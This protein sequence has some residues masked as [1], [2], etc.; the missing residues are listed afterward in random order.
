MNLFNQIQG[1]KPGYNAFDLSHERKFSMQMGKLTPILVQ[2]IIPGDKFNINTEV[3][4]RFAPLTAP[5]MHRINVY[6]HY[7]FV[8]NRLVWDDWQNFITGG[9][10]GL[11]LPVYP[12]LAMSKANQDNFVTGSLADYMGLPSLEGFTGS[13]SSN[14]W[15]SALPFRAYQ[16]IYNE[17]YRDQNLT[18]PVAFGTGSDAEADITA[19]M[20]MRQR[21]WE[22]DYFTSALPW[23]QRGGE[24]AMPIDFVY[25]DVSE[26]YNSVGVKPT[27]Q[28]DLS[29][30]TVGAT[31]GLLH[32]KVGDDPVDDTLRIENLESEGTSVTI[33]EL[34]NAVRLQEWLERNARAGARYIEQIFSHFGVKSSDA[35]LQRPEYLGG[36]KS[37]VVISEVLQTSATN[38]QSSAVDPSVQGNMAGHGISVGTGHKA[39]RRFEEHGYII[40]IISVLP[41]TAYQQGVNRMWRKDDKFDYF[42]PEFAQLGEQAIT[43]GE[44]YLDPEDLATANTADWGYQSRYAEYKYKESTVHGD[45]R[46]NLDHWHMG[47]EF[48][49]APE[50]NTSFVEADPTKRIFAVTDTTVDELWVQ[51]YHRIKAIRPIPYFNNP[52]I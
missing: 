6:T 44:L 51:L 35:R 29:A 32:N 14:Y 48:E 34:R 43:R 18:D 16:L 17:Y 21:A 13:F 27:T 26:V 28:I 31:D 9:S 11:D 24:V 52:T 1:K 47:R 8:P 38:T 19:L 5:V 22:K 45:F 41:R 15:V 40:G 10:D 39:S 23:A 46:T 49:T 42:W 36:G 33:N 37:P 2:E 20:T 3:L 30:G 12:T 25:K 4:M 7:F 50:L